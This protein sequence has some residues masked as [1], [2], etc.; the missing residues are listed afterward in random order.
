MNSYNVVNF[1]KLIISLNEPDI[2]KGEKV[3]LKVS[4]IYC[5]QAW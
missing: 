1:V 3:G 5:A 4:L 2:V